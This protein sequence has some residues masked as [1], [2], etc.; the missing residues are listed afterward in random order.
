MSKLL[1]REN[2]GFLLAQASRRWNE[3]LH[4]GFTREGF[5]RVRPSYGAVLVPLFE[6]DGLRLGELAA[7]SRLSKQTMT[8]MV[9]LL[10]REKLVRSR[11]DELDARATRVFLTAHAAAF[12][13]AAERVLAAL[14]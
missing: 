8:T 3:M 10:E 2:L 13:P 12:R 4:V 14:Q 11:R 7:R 1:H 9:R 5:A 6:R